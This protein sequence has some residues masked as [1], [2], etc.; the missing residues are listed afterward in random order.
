MRQLSHDRLSLTQKRNMEQGRCPV[1]RSD[2]TARRT[3]RWYS[4]V[5]IF[6]GHATVTVH[7]LSPATCQA[8]KRLAP[9]SSDNYGCNT[10]P[11]PI[12]FPLRSSSHHVKSLGLSTVVISTPVITCIGTIQTNASRLLRFEVGAKPSRCQV[13]LQQT[14]RHRMP[15]T[16]FAAPPFLEHRTKRIYVVNMVSIMT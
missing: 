12:K 7:R 16:T 3:Q 11:E 5:S 14:I 13:V 10:P 9:P 15:S 1:L 8:E 4:Q 2:V 6:D